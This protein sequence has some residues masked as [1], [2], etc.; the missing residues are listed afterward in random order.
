M[1]SSFGVGASDGAR[2]QERSNFVGG[3]VPSRTNCDGFWR[4][5]PQLAGDYIIRVAFNLGN[6]SAGQSKTVKVIYGRV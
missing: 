1:V 6:L 5:T 3:P 2:I 4:L